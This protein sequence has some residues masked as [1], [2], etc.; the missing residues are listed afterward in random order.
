[1][2]GESTVSLKLA[3][4]TRKTCEKLGNEEKMKNELLETQTRYICG[5]LRDLQQEQHLLQRGSIRCF[6]TLFFLFNH[7]T[8]LSQSLGSFWC[9]KSN[10]KSFPQSLTQ[11]SFYSENGSSKNRPPA[12]CRLPTTGL[13][14]NVQTLLPFD[15]KTV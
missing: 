1:M 15:N 5:G 9:S 3:F 7:S 12:D 11:V 14:P 2:T 8:S 4:K 10:S 13:G 6:F